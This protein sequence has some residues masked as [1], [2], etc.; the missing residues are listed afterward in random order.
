[1][2]LLFPMGVSNRFLK[3]DGTAHELRESIDVHIKDL[4]QRVTDAL[5]H[6]VPD[7]LDARTLRGRLPVG[8]PLHCRVISRP[9]V[10]PVAAVIISDAPTIPLHLDTVKDAADLETAVKRVADDQLGNSFDR[11]LA[12]F[13]MQKYVPF[14]TSSSVSAASV[15][16]A[17]NNAHSPSEQTH[18]K[19]LGCALLRLGIPRSSS[20]RS[21]VT[22]AMLH[23]YD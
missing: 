14:S 11:R 7:T 21:I 4:L 8:M 15:L 10:T 18:K 20:H 23:E 2:G 9:H 19:T 6:V 12:L 1:M 13:L 5:A 22:Y 3:V 16:A 17:Y